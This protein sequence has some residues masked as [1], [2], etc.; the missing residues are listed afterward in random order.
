MGAML[1][2]SSPAGP[3]RRASS[4]MSDV[5]RHRGGRTPREPPADGS[6]DDC[7]NDRER[8]KIHSDSA[9]ESIL[10][11]LRIRPGTARMVLEN[12]LTGDL[13]DHTAA[14]P[15]DPRIAVHEPRQPTSAPDH[16]RQRERDAED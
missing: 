2:A 8:M 11:R 15:H 7:K 3:R 13:A 9:G 10:D 12:H 5:L 6:D 16:D 14:Q 4:A 1:I